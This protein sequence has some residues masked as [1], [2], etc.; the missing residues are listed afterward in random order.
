M[1]ADDRWTWLRSA[2]A[3]AAPSHPPAAVRARLLAGVTIAVA[4]R[5]RVHLPDLELLSGWGPPLEVAVPEAV[6]ADPWLVGEA[7]EVLLD[8]DER[9]RRGSHHTPRPVADTVARLVLGGGEPGGATTACDPAAGGGAL[10][11]AVAEALR[12]SGVAKQAVVR[13]LAGTDVD[14]LAVAVTAAGLCLWAE[15]ARGAAIT[16]GD[17][18]SLPA[19]AWGEPGVVVAN[20][21]FL[22]QLRTA[23]SRGPDR[24]GL[25]PDLAALAGP[26]TDT[27]SLFAALATGIVAPGGRVALVVPRSFLVARDAGPARAA[28]T[29]AAALVHLWLPGRRVFGAAVDVCVPV[30]AQRPV[31]SR[32][33]PVSRSAG[34]PPAPAPPAPFP[35][36]A[37]TW[38]QLLSGLDDDVAVPSLA[39]VRSA[40][41]L[42]DHCTATAGFRDQYY[43]LLP[44]ALDDP[45]RDLD[46]TTH[47]PLVTCGLIDPARSEW[48]VREARYGRRRWA[49]PRVDVAAVAA[50]GGP[51]ARWVQGKRVPKV[52][53]AAQTRTIEA[54]ADAGGTWLP[55]TPVAT[56]VPTAGMLWHVLAVLLSPVASASAL[57]GTRGSGLSPGAIRLPPATLRALP[58]PADR[59]CWDAGA[60]AVREASTADGRADRS[61]HLEAAASSMCHAYGIEPDPAVRWWQERLP[62]P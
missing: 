2:A 6:Q 57:L 4:R 54:V 26:Y 50:A 55:S 34:L 14:P 25:R 47:A 60:A 17:A 8:V 22:G 61:A 16:C 58:V 56:V 10:L 11:L 39:G 30:W 41:V 23:T 51:L 49:A 33:R 24:S 59:S 3:A 48:G 19:Q 5:S 21:P 62:A 7:L 18:L 13:N 45:E 29:T 53:V 37:T 1:P 15:G 44:F 32:R 40:G 36:G 35:A 52:L 46:D 12:R 28:S 38:S 20:P 9:R 31:G 42:G 27:A 43:G